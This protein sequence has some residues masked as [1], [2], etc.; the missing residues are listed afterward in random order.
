MQLARPTTHTFRLAALIV[1]LLRAQPS[2]AESTILPLK[3]LPASTDSS[4]K[5][6]L[7]SR[8]DCHY[9]E[10]VRSEVLRPLLLGNH[11][12]EQLQIRELKIDQDT[13]VADADEKQVSGRELAA[14]Y[15]ANFTPSLLL[16]DANGR[17][18]G[19]ALVGVAN[20]E[21]Y[22]FY[23]ERKIKQAIKAR[24]EAQ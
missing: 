17:Q 23:V 22:S 10:F 20:P 5:L 2:L 7:V 19:T 6:V 16:F 12:G 21:M 4:V 3:N 9:C 18:M 8:Q 11:F 1:A 14:R 13:E 24:Q 15:K